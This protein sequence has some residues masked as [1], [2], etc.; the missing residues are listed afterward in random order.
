MN[1][2][3][4]R[5]EDFRQSNE[6]EGLIAEYERYR[7]GGGVRTDYEDNDIGSAWSTEQLINEPDEIDAPLQTS[8]LREQEKIIDE[9][10]DLSTFI[11]KA[12]E[13]G[14]N[15]EVLG[16]SVQD[17]SER[18]SDLSNPSS[19]ST[20]WWNSL[21]QNVPYLGGL[22]EPDSGRMLINLGDEGYVLLTG[23]IQ[24]I[25]DYKIWMSNLAPSTALFW[26]FPL[27]VGIDPSVVREAEDIMIGSRSSDLSDFINA[28][29]TGSVDINGNETEAVPLLSWMALQAGEQSTDIGENANATESDLVFAAAMSD[30]TMFVDPM[31][32][33]TAD[34]LVDSIRAIYELAKTAPVDQ[35]RDIEE[36]LED[37]LL[38]ILI[39]DNRWGITDRDLDRMVNEIQDLERELQQ[40][41]DVLLAQEKEAS[42]SLTTEL[43]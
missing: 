13:I 25:E 29:R 16:Q 37:E 24:S 41:I 31:S 20:T 33:S 2:K 4:Y 22:V 42:D 9:V 7:Y 36:I 35:Q 27:L 1:E 30:R 39:E 11:D 40:D 18:L 3:E 19:E 5:P 34:R 32:D 15:S 14:L 10:V 38:D 26:K 8:S 21:L 28:V 17:L 43:S 6:E 12:G 23:D